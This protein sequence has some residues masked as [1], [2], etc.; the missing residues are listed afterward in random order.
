MQMAHD[1]LQQR[2]KMHIFVIANI[3]YL[4]GITEQK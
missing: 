4:H 2:I 3:V 1:L